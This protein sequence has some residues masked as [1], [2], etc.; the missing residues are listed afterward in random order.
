MKHTILFPLLL[1]VVALTAQTPRQPIGNLLVEGI[2]AIPA[3]LIERLEQYQNTRA[4]RFVDWDAKGQGLYISTRFGDVPQIHHVA[5]PGGSRTQITFFKEPIG[6]AS[7]C[8]AEGMDGFLFSRDVG[9]NENFQ[10]YY[11]D[12]KTGKSTLLTDGKSRHGNARWN[13]RGD[14]ICYTSTKRTGRDLDF[15]IAPLK[16]PASAKMVLQNT[17]GGW[18]ISDW[19]DDDSRM[20]VANYI[21]ANESKLFLLEVAS[22][23]L[24]QLNPVSQQ[25]SYSGARFSKDGKGIYLLSDEGSDFAAL[26]YMDMA[27][28]NI[29][30]LIAPNWDV[31]GMDISDDGRLLA[32]TVN[33]GGFYKAYLLDLTTRQSRPLKLPANSL[34]GGL[35][36]HP[37]NKRIAMTIGSATSTGDAYVYDLGTDNMERW[38]YSETGGLNPDNFV[39]CQLIQF[40]TFDKDEQ[41]GK[42]RQVPAFLY[43]PK[44]PKGKV[45]VVIN[46]HGG[47]EGQSSPGFSPQFQ[48]MVNELGIAVLDPNVRGSSGYGKTYLKL[49]NG[50]L[51]EN[52]V[53]DIGAL[54]DWIATQPN[55]D[56]S[57]VAVS[58]GSYGGY[59]SLACMTHFNDRLR[60]G[61]DLF[62]ISNFVT[63][64]KNTSGYRVDLRRVEYG[65]ERDPAMAEHL[66]KISPLTNIKK[67]TKPMFIYQGENDP[68]VPLSESEQM[69][70]LLKQQGVSTWYVRAKDEGHGIAKKAN[71]DYTQAAMM[72][73]WQE[74]LLK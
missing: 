43:M 55:L 14:K 44:N 56:A 40:P 38:T 60:C 30:K 52:S 69:L 3:S 51:R 57:R 37:D 71:R 10:A 59:M 64:L 17:G 21:S 32:Y 12:R 19:S 25:I 66:Q 39:N 61:I 48:F 65:D 6:G 18:G 34:V 36:F 74:F 28:R 9:G 5:K 24:E 73:F 72:L 50:M 33:E 54:L 70:E 22:G 15:Y 47:P 13:K 35:D 42:P 46:I 8:P 45:P 16:D 4:A 31:A 58:G 20:L 2:P 68:R 1:S 7:S 11:F 26:Y 27:G 29:T 49:D 63:F 67:I 41:T 23:K 62:G 53:K